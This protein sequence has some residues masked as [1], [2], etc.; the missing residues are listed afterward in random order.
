MRTLEVPDGASAAVCRVR[1]RMSLKEL[2]VTVISGGRS[3]ARSP[4]AKHTVTVTATG[5]ASIGCLRYTAYY[6][7]EPRLV[8]ARFAHSFL[9]RA[10]GNPQDSRHHRAIWIPLTVPATGQPRPLYLVPS[11]I[12]MPSR[13]A[14]YPCP[15]APNRSSKTDHNSKGHAN[16]EPN[17]L[18]VPAST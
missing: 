6:E 15:S 11:G 16:D 5:S 3:V 9:H 4:V 13:A 2:E 7:A 18:F 1:E 8:G 10:Q 14:V 12:M 17:V